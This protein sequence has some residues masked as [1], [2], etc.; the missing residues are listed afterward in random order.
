M[1][2]LRLEVGGMTCASC[3]ASIES[4]LSETKGVGAA[5]VSLLTESAEVTYAPDVITPEQVVQA[6]Q[7]IGKA[8][9]MAP[10][11]EVQTFF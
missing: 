8:C 10:G 9:S 3:V 4:H 6:V 1:K 11:V 7:D 2:T 5:R